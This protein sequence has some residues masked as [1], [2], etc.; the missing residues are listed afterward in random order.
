MIP[1]PPIF[2]APRVSNHHCYA[3]KAIMISAVSVPPSSLRSWPPN[4]SCWCPLRPARLG[5]PGVGHDRRW[6]EVAGFYCYF[7]SSFVQPHYITLL[8]GWFTSSGTAVNG[9]HVG[10]P[11]SCLCMHEYMS[12]LSHR[13][14]D[15]G[16]K[17]LHLF[18][19]FYPHPI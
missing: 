17:P 8:G 14:F 7:R 1:P 4:A 5:R 19:P 9:T 11:Y 16:L 10:P 12:G 2:V 3:F 15:R 6:R 13:F 18:P